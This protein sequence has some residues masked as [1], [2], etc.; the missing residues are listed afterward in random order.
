M[1]WGQ[2]LLLK[3]MKFQKFLLRPRYGDWATTWDEEAMPVQDK[4]QDKSLDKS[5]KIELSL[6]PEPT[7][8]SGSGWGSAGRWQGQSLPTQED[9]PVFIFSCFYPKSK[10]PLD[11]GLMSKVRGVIN[12][13]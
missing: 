13:H 10:K 2:E 5:G 7:H 6:F 1:G 11:T 8:E 4:S 3:V 9:D 12:S